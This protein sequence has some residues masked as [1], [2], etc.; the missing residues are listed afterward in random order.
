M[1]GSHDMHGSHGSYGIGMLAMVEHFF[2]KSYSDPVIKGE[3][4]LSNNDTKLCSAYV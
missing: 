2:R 4:L 1:H 3:E